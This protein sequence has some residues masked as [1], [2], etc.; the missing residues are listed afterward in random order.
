M[1]GNKKNQLTQYDQIDRWR[2]A[3]R[4]NIYT[5]LAE[6]YKIV[7]V[8]GEEQGLTCNRSQRRIVDVISNERKQGRSP[9]IAVLKS[10]RRGISTGVTGFN[11]HDCYTGQNASGVVMT[12]LKDVTE[13]QRTN[14][15][16]AYDHLPP[17]LQMEY[18][19]KNMDALGWEHNNSIIR[20]GSAENP[21]FSIGRTVRQF[22]GSEYSRWPANYFTTILTDNLLAVPRSL[23]A[24][25]ILES[26]ARG[27]AHPSFSF[28]E[29]CEKGNLPYVPI[30]LKWWEDE[31]AIVPPWQNQRAQ[32]EAM[33]ECFLDF[34]EAKDRMRHFLIE[35][36]KLQPE[37]A[38]RRI[39]WYWL[40]Y[41]ELFKDKKKL[42][43]NFPMT[44]KEAFI[45]SGDPWYPMDIVDAMRLECWEGKLF[46]PTIRFSQMNKPTAAAGLRREIDT[47]M[48]IWRAPKAGVKYILVADSATGTANGDFSAAGVFELETG[49][50]H[51]VIHGRMEIAVFADMIIDLSD[52]YHHCKVAPEAKGTGGTA[53]M[54]MLKYKK[55]KNFWNRKKPGKAGRAW[56]PTMEYG[57][58][59]NQ[60]TRPIMLQQSKRLM[61]ERFNNKEYKGL[62][63]SAHILDQMRTFVERDGKPE[64]QR[65]M[66]DDLVMMWNIGVMICIIESANGAVSTGLHETKS[67]IREVVEPKNLTV[68]DTL[69]MIQ[70]S[71]WCGESYTEFYGGKK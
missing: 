20:F 2:K 54:E 34:P 49:N 46:D 64:H 12:H 15:L 16:Y 17:Y 51:A 7:N 8:D 6:D 41:R 69:K 36:D 57:W 19:K 13:D 4:G 67:S 39:Y 71:R 18:S 52:L 28:W 50:L 63:P 3:A 30:F 53:L 22:H 42:Q 23:E 21:D 43:E 45:A 65:G 10:R 35:Q 27:T 14:M 5:F 60:N 61:R 31:D 55:F 37:E 44:A 26:T 40:Q 24:W 11:F 62:I 58:D 56:E 9:R 29:E 33:L 66:H 48:E 70:D 47:Y 59:T 1:A 68:R 32:D 25:V 38:A